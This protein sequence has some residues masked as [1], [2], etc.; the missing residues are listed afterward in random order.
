MP[1]AIFVF[2]TISASI[3]LIHG[4]HFIELKYSAAAF[5]SSSVMDFANPI[6]MFVLA[7]LVSE[8]LRAPLLNSANCCIMKL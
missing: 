8:L 7:F 5:V 1:L 4:V 6:M 2:G 3:T